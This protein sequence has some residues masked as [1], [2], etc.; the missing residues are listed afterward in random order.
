MPGELR[1]DLDGKALAGAA[2][3]DRSRGHDFFD[4]PFQGRFVQALFLSFQDDGNHHFDLPTRSGVPD[5]SPVASSIASHAGPRSIRIE[6]VQRP[7]KFIVSLP[8][9]TRVLR[10]PRERMAAT[11]YRYSTPLVARVTGLL[12]MTGLIEAAKSDGPLLLPAASTATTR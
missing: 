5:S 3:S 12:K 4:P 10:S 2:S 11:W 1:A 7:K 9:M 8:P 6:A